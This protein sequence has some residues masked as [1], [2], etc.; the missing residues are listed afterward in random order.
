MIHHSASKSLDSMREYANNNKN[1]NINNNNNHN[2]GISGILNSG[3]NNNKNKKKNKNTNID[4]G[5]GGVLYE[6]PTED[7]LVLNDAPTVRTEKTFKLSLSNLSKIK[8]LVLNA[9]ITL[10]R[11]SGMNTVM[12][13]IVPKIGAMLINLIHFESTIFKDNEYQLGTVIENFQ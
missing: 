12:D 4:S 6:H 2:L 8:K 10:A 1:N 13:S 9:F 5:A 3:K 11:Q 7:T